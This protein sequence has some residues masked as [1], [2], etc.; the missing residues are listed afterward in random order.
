MRLLLV[1]ACA[2]RA[3]AAATDTSY[4][5]E[6]D[7][8]LFEAR[9][10]GD[11]A[12]VRR[13]LDAGA[14]VNAGSPSNHQTTLFNAI[15]FKQADIIELLLSR[16][17]DARVEQKNGF[18]A[19]D[20]AAFSGNA[21]VVPALVALGLDPA[22]RRD[23]ERRSGRVGRRR[24]GA[25]VEALL[26]AGVDAATT[27][28]GRTGLPV[29]D[30]TRNSATKRAIANHIL[31][32]HAKVDVSALD[33]AATTVERYAYDAARGATDVA[34]SYVAAGEA[35]RFATTLHTPGPAAAAPPP[36]PKPGAVDPDELETAERRRTAGADAPP[37]TEDPITSQPKKESNNVN[38][39]I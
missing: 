11:V 31:A 39:N 23:G 34:I 26:L 3:A 5:Q 13:A 16:G 38:L 33:L 14:N 10:E 19:L 2:V 1:V 22:R 35:R 8:A 37:S 36:K 25:T 20:A 27:F 30:E 6:R 17:A 21:D 9:K 12:A 32:R 29:Y 18:T 4:V 7:G 24:Q 28:A 15:I